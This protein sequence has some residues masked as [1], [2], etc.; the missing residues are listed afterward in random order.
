MDGARIGTAFVDVRGDFSSINKEAAAFSARLGKTGK[1]AGGV[2]AVG[3][4]AVIAGKALYDVGAEFD[5]AYDKIR[6]GTGKTGKQLRRLKND[7]RA[8][9]GTVPTDFD[10]AGT[11][12]AELNK[13]LGVS[14]KPLRKLSRQFLELSRIT[15]TDL[16]GNI[17]TVTRLF[18]DW[19]IA[20]KQQPKTLDKLFRASQQTGIEIS[21]LSEYMV[22]FG[23]PL[24]QMGFDFDTAA[25]MF[26]KFEKEGVNLQTAMPGLRMALKNFAAEGRDPAKALRETIREIEGMG[27]TAKANTKAFEVFGTRAGP[28]LAAAIREGRFDFDSLIKTIRSGKDTIRKAGKETMDGAEGWQLTLNK[29]KL[30]IEPVATAVFNAWGDLGEAASKIDFQKLIKDLGLTKQTF[31][32]VGVA[33][34]AVARFLGPILGDVLRGAIQAFR[35]FMQVVRGVAQVISGILTGDFGKAWRGVKNIFSGGARFIVGNLRATTAPF[36]A[37]AGKI[38]DAL[39]DKLGGAWD[40]VEDRFKDGLEVIKDVVDKILDVVELIPGVDIRGGDKPGRAK[41]GRRRGDPAGVSG[42]TPQAR[43]SGGPITKPT[44]IV[45]EEAPRHHEWVIATNP[46]YKQD[47]L[48]YWAA[49]GRDLGV[50]GFASGGIIGK[51]ADFLVDKLPKPNIP[52]PLSGVGPWMIEQAAKFIKGKEKKAGSFAGLAVANGP[53]KKMAK[54]MVL[55]LWGPGEW[56]P[57][58]ALEMGEAR[59]NPRA[60]NASSGAAGLAQALPP[61]KY[62][63]GAWPYRGLGSAKLQLQWMMQYIRERYGSPSSA[64]SAWLSRE[65]HWYARGGLMGRTRQRAM[66]FLAAGGMVDPSF[67]PGGETIAS[68]IARL[69]GAYAKRYDIDITAGYDPGGGHVSP[70]HNSTG[71]ATDVVPRSGNW[72]GAFAN[73][74]RLLASL[75]FEVGYDGS[76][77]GTENWPDHGRGN[78]AHIEWVGNG[79]APDARQRLRDALGGAGGAATGSASSGDGSKAK[80]QAGLTPGY[81]VG[82]TFGPLPD[83]VKGC[84][85]ELHVRRQQ[86]R[87]LEKAKKEGGEGDKALESSLKKVKNRIEALVKRRAK[88]IAQHRK[89][90]AKSIASRGL[91]PKLAAMLQDREGDYELAAQDA[92]R[93]AALEPENPDAGYIGK[94]KG[95][96]VNVLGTLTGWRNAV[97]GAR[98]FAASRIPHFAR[99]IREIEAWKVP[100]IPEFMKRYNKLKWRIPALRQAITNATGFVGERGENLTDLQGLGG[101][102]TAIGDLGEASPWWLTL[103]GPGARIFD[104]QNTIRELGLRNIGG[105]GAGDTERTEAL[106]KLLREANL[107]TAVSERQFKTMKDFQAVY[108]FMGAHAQGGVAL[109]GERGPELAHMPSGTRIHSAQDTAQMLQPTVYVYVYEGEGRAEVEVNG[110]RLQANVRKTPISTR[111]TPGG[112]RR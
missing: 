66:Q 38:G 24:R 26:S 76:I 75:G 14:G 87:Q 39:T 70:G 23:S 37:V 91:F 10:D 49:A 59:W 43:F 29:L 1:L 81:P 40:W 56:A 96:W 92:E 22:Q 62:P 46:A 101:P 28:D 34:K 85:A 51:G 17:Q 83:T 105:D 4:A 30:A 21:K 45:G 84:T 89:K 97:V 55:A 57:F 36:R 47:N 2:A 94:E 103:G 53:I 112:A 13:R 52:Q 44:A 77:A 25:A 79:T 68:S 11:A 73:G 12:I 106:E 27:S 19:G 20:T 108:P 86:L 93:V 41:P 82:I 72:D 50:P 100:G 15:D 48:K 60:V 35:G 61:S 18:G 102:Q 99:E 88:I 3:A 107:R 104:T 7:F 95:A 16:A 80:P 74:L 111:R 98:D 5:G 69:V 63:P 109:V 58:N 33:V 65:P 6:V 67:D 8:V 9:V 71:T 64:Y 32:D 90:V 54:E 42:P 78:H 31:H 110:R